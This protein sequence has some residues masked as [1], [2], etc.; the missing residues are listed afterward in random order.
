MSTTDLAFEFRRRLDGRVYRFVPAE[1]RDGRRAWR[2]VD[3]PL[4]LA[5]THERGWTVT[6]EDGLVLSAPWDF[7]KAL[8][9]ALPPETIWI[10]R[11]GDKSYVYELRGAVPEDGH[12]AR[13]PA[14][15]V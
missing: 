15:Q 9:G 5:W 10:S 11:K 14:L 13:P 8:Q 4:S 1:D 2:R 7:D 12:E 3:L 6:D